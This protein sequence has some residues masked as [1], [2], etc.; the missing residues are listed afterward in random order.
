MPSLAEIR[1]QIDQADRRLIAALGD[2]LAAVAAIRTQKCANGDEPFDPGREAEVLANAR[3]AAAAAGIDESASLEAVRAVIGASRRWQ[4]RAQ[5]AESAPSQ[6]GDVIAVAGPAGSFSWAAAHRLLSGEEQRLLGCPTIA[7]ACRAAGQGRAAGA[8]V[9]ISNSIAGP[10]QSTRR[11]IAEHDLVVRGELE[12]PIELC[13][14]AP[15]GGTLSALQTVHSHP[16]ALAQCRRWLADHP[17]L[18]TVAASTTSA[19]GDAV[20]AAGDTAAAAIMSREAAEARSLTVL[21]ADIADRPDNHT[22]FWLVSP[23]R[24]SDPPAAPARLAAR[25]SGGDRTVVRIGRA[26]VGGDR[27]VVMAGPCAV[28]SV[29]Q[30]DAAANAVAAAGALVLRGGAYKPRTSPYA[31]QG[32]GPAG[33]TMLVEAGRAAGLPVVTEVLEPADVVPL[34]GVVDCLQIGARNMQNYPLLRAAGRVRRPVLLKRGPSATLD[35]LLSAAEYILEAGNPHVILCERGIRTFETATRNTL[36]LSAVVVLKERTHLPVIVDPSHA[37]GRSAWVPNLALAA[38]AVGADGLIVEV[39]PDPSTARCDA[40][41][42]VAT[43][44]LPALMHAL[45]R[46][47]RP[48]R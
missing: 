30:M 16:M 20:A 44:D 2:R 9:P 48:A 26:E 36:D 11:A 17:R 22:T 24:E 5:L 15:S 43:A 10:V 31:F 8:L 37:A 13:A 27:F 21:A 41:Q 19:A 12:E 4:Q 34:A 38:K 1:K 45:R 47:P 28:E 18:R 33:V 25:A 14:A 46:V 42:A 29:A 7:E 40:A 23:R 3:A 39:H 35:E 6:A 32:L